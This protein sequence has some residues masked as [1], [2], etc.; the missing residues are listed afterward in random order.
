MEL[1]DLIGETDEED[2]KEDE[3]IG[4][5]QEIQKNEDINAPGSLSGKSSEEKKIENMNI[6]NKSMNLDNFVKVMKSCGDIIGN[7]GLIYFL[8]FEKIYSG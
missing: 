1:I 7:L 5:G 3:I 6:G 8:L 4:Q 2:L